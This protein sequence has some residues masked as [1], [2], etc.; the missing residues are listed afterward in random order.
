[1]QPPGVE[2][3]KAVT[4]LITLVFTL[5]SD[6]S[7]RNREGAQG[8]PVIS[9]ERLMLFMQI[10]CGVF[11]TMQTLVDNKLFVFEL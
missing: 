11:L 2:G 7:V 10:R 9:D 1:M 5:P 4:K 8:T 3:F 6:S